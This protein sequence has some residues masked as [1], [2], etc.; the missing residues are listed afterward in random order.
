MSNTTYIPRTDINTPT[1]M[2]REG[3]SNNFYYAWNTFYNSGWGAPPHVGNCTWYAWGRFW[4]ISGATSST[5]KRPTL[6]TGNAEDW[7]PYTADGYERGSTPRLGA[8]LC[9]RDGAYSGWGHVAIVEEIEEDGSIWT[10]ESGLESQST[11]LGGFYFRYVKR[12]ASDYVYDPDDQYIF[13][14]F[15]YNPY[16]GDTPGTKIKPWLLGSALR[17]RKKDDI[18]KSRF[19]VAVRDKKLIRFKEEPLITSC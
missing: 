3:L 4:E 2:D 12:R 5:E 17:R 18:G 13:Q 8:I 9:M 14:G 19:T 10:S 6:N 16:A 15:I 7:Y 1:P 11:G